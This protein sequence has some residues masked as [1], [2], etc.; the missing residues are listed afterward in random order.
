[1]HMVLNI[2]KRLLDGIDLARLHLYYHTLS[3]IDSSNQDYRDHVAALDLLQQQPPGG[4]AVNY[5]LLCR[6]A[7]SCADWVSV[8]TVDW[9]DR[10]LAAMPAS[11]TDRLSA[12]RLHLMLAEKVFFQ[13]GARTDN[14]IEAFRSVFCC[15][16]QLSIYVVVSGFVRK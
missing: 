4:H 15:I 3:Q 2:K 7:E 11:C 12:A 9:L 8:E 6:G 14:W 10:V 16:F 5:N 1:M 13:H